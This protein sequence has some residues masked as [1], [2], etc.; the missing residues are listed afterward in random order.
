MILQMFTFE[1]VDKDYELKIKESL[2][3]KPDNLLVY[4]SPR[5]SRAPTGTLLST[6]APST[7]HQ[8]ISSIAEESLG[9]QPATIL[10]GS[11]SG[12]CEALAHRLAVEINGRGTFLCLVQPMDAFEGRRLPKAQPVII[13]TGSYDGSPPDNAR[14][15]VTW[16]QSL[17]GKE[18]EGVSYAVFGCGKLESFL[19][20]S[21]MS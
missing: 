14:E 5:P 11:N 4:A 9:V 19:R 20:D 15:F 13:I 3:I 2:T 10:Y 1:L 12:T 7:T 21:P 6:H 17:E 16:L 18:L 8:N